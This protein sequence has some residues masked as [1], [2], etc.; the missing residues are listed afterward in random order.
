M[1]N[2]KHIPLVGGTLTWIGRK[3]P[4]PEQLD[5]FQKMIDAANQQRELEVDH[6]PGQHNR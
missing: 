5:V 6:E 2:R 1:K 4:S 3:D